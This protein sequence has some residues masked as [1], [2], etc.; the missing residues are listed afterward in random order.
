MSEGVTTSNDNDKDKNPG[1]VKTWLLAFS[2]FLTAATGAIYFAID[3]SVKAFSDLFGGFGADL[4]FLTSVLIDYSHYFVVFTV[5]ALISLVLFFRERRS[6]SIDA[7]RYFSW[8]VWCFG[9]SFV[10]LGL[11]TV[12]MYLPIFKLGATVSST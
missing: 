10:L 1:P 6:D 11:F 4:P 8:I 2:V 7:N 3:L 12:A 9:L 5:G